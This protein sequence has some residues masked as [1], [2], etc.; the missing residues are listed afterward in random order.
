MTILGWILLTVGL[1]FIVLNYGALAVNYR[2]RSWGID[3]HRSFVPIHGGVLGAAG[4]YVLGQGALA[5]V[6][7]GVDPGIWAMALLLSA[8]LRSRSDEGK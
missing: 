4:L 8:L 5:L 6:M 2:N 3:R 7:A 1:F